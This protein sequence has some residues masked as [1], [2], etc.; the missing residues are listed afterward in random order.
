MTTVDETAEVLWGRP[1]RDPPIR[2]GEDYI[3]S[4]RGRNLSVRYMGAPVSEPVDHPVIRP[5]INA[6][7][8]TVDLALEQP[9]LA[10]AHS[11]ISGRTVNRF[12]HVAM[13]AEDV[14]AQNRMQ[15]TLGQQTGTCFQRC[16]GMDALNTM[17]SITFDCDAA[18]HTDYHERFRSFL[19]YVQEENLI[20]GGA[21]TDPKGDRS[22]G[23]ADQADPDLFLHVVERRDDGVVLRGA[24]AHQTGCI[25]SHWIVVMPTMRMRDVDRD[26]AVVAAIPVEHPGL[27]FVYGRQSCDSRALEGVDQGNAQFA[28]Q[29]AL[30]IIDDVFVP[31]EY[32]FLDGEVEYAAP[33]V[34]R[35]TGFH[36]RSYVC[37]TGLGDVLIGASAQLAEWNGVAGAGHIRDKLVEMVHL[38]ETIYGAGIAASHQSTPTAA[39][40]FQ[41][42]QLLANV[43]KHNVTRFPYELGRLAQDIGGGIV[44]TMPSELDFDDPDTGPLLRKY[45]ATVPGINAE[46]RM[47][48]LRLV[49]NMTMG[50]NAVGY[51]TESMHGAGSPQAQRIVM[52]RLADL[53]HKKTLARHLAGVEDAGTDPP[54]AHSTP[55]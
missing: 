46:D 1:R 15:R 19:R 3:E 49:E 20:I 8:R 32:V 55:E 16:V 11:E 43:C 54:A 41:P 53:E 25:N 4:L 50:R 18:K 33:L 42:D 6:M 23:P 12:L 2:T 37:K 13:S 14:V 28:G 34:D 52:A 17:Y 21:M 7:A 27:S 38:N 51:L 44:A 29:E 22:A 24:K 36:R 9:E 47:R 35:F 10:S 31:N 26:Y 40:N 30:I 5:S 48:V 39:G 45:F